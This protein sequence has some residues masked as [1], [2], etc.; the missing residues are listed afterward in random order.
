MVIEM[1][2]DIEWGL[3]LLSHGEKGYIL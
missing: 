3:K 1:G 2:K